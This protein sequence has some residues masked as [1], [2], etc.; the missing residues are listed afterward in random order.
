MEQPRTN[1]ARNGDVSIAYQVVGSAPV[2]LVLVPGFVSHLDLTWTLPEAAAFM[3]AL[4]SF[5][6]LIVFDKR[7][8]GLSDP[9]PEVPTLEE[10][11]EDLHA[12]LDAAGSERPA[13]LGISEGGPMSISF[14]ATHP[15][16]VSSL[17]LYGSSPR[18]S[19]SQDFLPE[20]REFFERVRRETRSVVEHWG[21][22]RSV[23]WF[24]PSVAGDE[25]MTRAFGLWERASASPAMVR[26]L[27]A[28]WWEIDVTDVLEVIGVPTL[29]LHRTGERVLPV[30]AGRY[31]ANGIPGARL[32]EQPG[33][34]H[35]PFADAE[36]V[37][38][39]IE[40]FLTGARKRQELD[41]ALATVLFTDIVSST[42]RAAELGDQRW[43]E[44]LE[45]HDVAVRRQ[46]EAYGGRVVKSLGDGYLA[47]FNGPARAI[48]CGCELA[49]DAKALGLRLRVAAHTGECELLGD[50]VAG[51][52][53]HITARV[54][55]N[56][57]P[58][59]M[60]VSSSVRDLVV[61]SGIQFADRG[62]HD[63]KGVPGRWTLLAVEPTDRAHSQTPATRP[64]TDR[65][66]PN[67]DTP[68]R[69]DRMTLR[70]ARHAP[71]VARFL[72][73]VSTRSR[74]K[75]SVTRERRS[76]R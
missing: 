17:I 67:L 28:A 4:A 63:L 74:Q 73:G 18:F 75:H 40:R 64:A 5:V 70:I 10:R 22:G 27:F 6:R 43:R 32:V 71:T 58:D 9:V 46:V 76:T 20:R 62:T 26:A 45:A 72:T 52:A 66:A 55:E 37:I 1:Y 34:D 11:M 3:R 56:A 35:F 61:G 57:R 36:P 13:L 23:E 15:E 2:D 39:E 41:R 50:D 44:L 59:E 14:A 53:V 49:E 42:D 30:E 19:S 7:G 21:E 47:T 25:R 8:T 48:R 31:L 54:L 65:L 60:L 69:G 16:R 33:V 38:G 29:V 51:I 68:R 24:W 12:V